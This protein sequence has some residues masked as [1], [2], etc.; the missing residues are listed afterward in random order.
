MKHTLQHSKFR[1]ES[2][3]WFPKSIEK[4]IHNHDILRELSDGNCPIPVIVIPA[5]LSNNLPGTEFTIGMS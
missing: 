3:Q 5:T 4:I 1:K 2:F